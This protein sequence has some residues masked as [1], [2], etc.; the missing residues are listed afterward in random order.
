MG[1]TTVGPSKNEQGWRRMVV[2][3]NVPSVPG[4]YGIVASPDGRLILFGGFDTTSRVLAETWEFTF[5][6]D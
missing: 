3:S 5:L 2:E 6:D 4:S 1:V